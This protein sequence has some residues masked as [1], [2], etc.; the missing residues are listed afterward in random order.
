MK[1]NDAIRAVSKAYGK[2]IKCDTGYTAMVPSNGLD[3]SIKEI[4]ADN[5][6]MIRLQ[7]AYL[8][9]V[10][11]LLLMGY[12]RADVE[13]LVNSEHRFGSNF[14]GIVSKAHAHIKMDRLW[15]KLF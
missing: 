4:K 8:K 6:R 11:A 9:A 10:D 2:P 13:Y 14:R 3:G 12:T 1:M 15:R 7:L 5:Y